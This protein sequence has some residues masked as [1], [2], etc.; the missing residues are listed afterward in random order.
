MTNPYYNPQELGLDMISF[1][2]DDLCYAF[3]TLCFWVVK[4]STGSVFT[5]QDSGCS[6][7][8]PFEDYEG[9][10][11]SDVLRKLDYIDTGS[12]ALRVFDSW[13]VKCDKTKKCSD[14]ERDRLIEWL[15]EKCFATRK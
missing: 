2:R 1:D 11:Q 12:E 3:D 4:G 6:C 8:T 9:D 13:N 5:A 14:S 15:D 10:G 7:P